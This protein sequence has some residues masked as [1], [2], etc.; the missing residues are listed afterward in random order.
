MRTLIFAA[1]AWITLAG[2][3]ASPPPEYPASRLKFDQAL[4]GRWKSVKADQPMEVG[5]FTRYP[6][7]ETVIEIKSRDVPLRNGRVDSM[8]SE[9]GPR[10]TVAKGYQVIQ[11]TGKGAIELDGFLFEAGGERLFGMQVSSKQISDLA[12]MVLPLHFVSRITIVGDEMRIQV[13]QSGFAWVPYIGWIDAEPGAKREFAWSPPKDDS[14][15]ATPTDKPTSIPILLVTS[16]IDR[17]IEV[18]EKFMHE[19]GFWG[20]AETYK[21]MKD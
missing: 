12:M 7:V 9:G 10:E 19:P 16:D 6:D 1:F 21:R 5:V 3:T 11:S 20:E 4:I 15:S 18:Y 13:A 8:A 2:C 14:S 17:L